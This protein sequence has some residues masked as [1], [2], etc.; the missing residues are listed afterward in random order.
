MLQHAGC[1][2]SALFTFVVTRQG[3]S[4]QIWIGYARLG[5][6]VGVAIK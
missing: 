5:Q 1:P 4:K 2:P 3:H 6:E